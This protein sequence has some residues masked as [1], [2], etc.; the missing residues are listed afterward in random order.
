[1]H[2]ERTADNDTVLT[3]HVSSVQ[4]FILISVHVL[5]SICFT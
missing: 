4:L 3:Y 2:F 5:V 1:M